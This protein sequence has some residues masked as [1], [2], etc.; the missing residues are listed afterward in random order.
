MTRYDF[1]Y[2]SDFLIEADITPEQLK[3]EI[4]DAMSE[5]DPSE[6]LWHTLLTIADFFETIEVKK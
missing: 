4:E 6:P 1:S 5:I 3:D 2:A